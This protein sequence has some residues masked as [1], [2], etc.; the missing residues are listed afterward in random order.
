MRYSTS[1]YPRD[2]VVV[3]LD[4][5]IGLLQTGGLEWGLTHQQSVPERT[6]AVS[7]LIG[8][9]AKRCPPHVLVYSDLQYAPKRPDVHLVAVAL[10][11]K[12]FWCDVV[13]S[14]TQGLLPLAIKLDLSG[15]TKVP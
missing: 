14:S 3:F 8:S 13:G 5:A 6:Q 12:H 11:A 7:P 2:S 9:A 10:L 1:A 4:A 15:Q